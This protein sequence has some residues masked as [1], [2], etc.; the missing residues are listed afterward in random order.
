MYK[1]YLCKPTP[2]PS[3]LARSVSLSL[4][5]YVFVSL[6]SSKCAQKEG[7][8]SS[9]PCS[10]CANGMNEKQ[11]HKYFYFVYAKEYGFTLNPNVAKLSALLVLPLLN[12]I[13]TRRNQTTHTHTYTHLHT[14]IG[15]AE[16][17]GG[18]ECE[19]VRVLCRKIV[20]WQILFC[21][22]RGQKPKNFPK[23][24]FNCTPKQPFRKNFWK[25]LIVHKIG[26][27]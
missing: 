8:S 4:S 15:V 22:C 6:I 19:C 1:V 21:Q 2:S 16:R 17:N 23:T 26:I 5:L 7:I 20:I 11:V 12:S 25:I 14:D 18:C 27:V 9:Q 13:A 3:P 10:I 24:N